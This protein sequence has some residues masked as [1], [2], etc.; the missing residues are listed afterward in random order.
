[1]TRFFRGGGVVRITRCVFHESRNNKKMAFSLF[2]DRKCGEYR[3][4][5]LWIGRL[6]IKYG[7]AYHMSYS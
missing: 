7:Y 3:L 6:L 2:T 1:M 4:V 5:S